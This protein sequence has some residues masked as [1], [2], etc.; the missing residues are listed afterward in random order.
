KGLVNLFRPRRVSAGECAQESV[1][2]H[3]FR[4]RFAACHPESQGINPMTVFVIDLAEFALA[5]LG[6]RSQNAFLSDRSWI[7]ACHWPNPFSALPR[8]FFRRTVAHLD[9]VQSCCPRNA[10]GG[11]VLQRNL[12]G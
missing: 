12:S 4:S 9:L 10:S 5:A 8:M 2:S 7:T 6:R 11:Q 1:G 3:L